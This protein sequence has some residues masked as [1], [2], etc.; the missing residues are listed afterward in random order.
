MSF[1][2]SVP[3]EINILVA[4]LRTPVLSFHRCT[5]PAKLPT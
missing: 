5:A 3:H 4:H 1:Y 2:P